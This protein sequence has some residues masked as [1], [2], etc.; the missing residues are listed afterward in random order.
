M[1]RRN[2]VL[3]VSAALVLLVVAASVDAAVFQC[4][5]GDV[6]CLIAAVN[7]A[8]SNGEDNTIRLAAGIYPIGGTAGVNGLSVSL[9]PSVSGKLTIVGA[10]SSATILEAVPVTLQFPW[11]SHP[12]GR[13][14]SY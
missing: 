7:A 13:P 6:D 3:T 8:N 1:L 11:P 2:L 5:S 12:G 4:G 10:G 9:L 14:S